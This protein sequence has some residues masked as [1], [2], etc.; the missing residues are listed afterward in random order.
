MGALENTLTQADID[1][2]MKSLLPANGEDLFQG[3]DNTTLRDYDFRRP[4]KFKK[5]LLRTLVMVHENYARLLQSFFLA[6]LRT[7]TQVH[8]RGTNQYLYAEYT[9]LLP[10][11]AVVA[12]FRLNP[13]PGICLLEISANIAY[14]VIDRVFGGPGSDTQ[15]QRG[16]SEIELSVIQRT[17][18]DVFVPLQEAWRNVAEIKPVLEAMETNPAFLQTS[19]P[20]EVLA[21]ITLGVQVGEHIGN[22]T[23]VFPYSTV[24]PVMS[25]LSPHRWL[26][27]DP[28]GEPDG[29]GLQ[30]SIQEA[31]VPLTAMLG[32]ARIT[33][34]EFTSLQEGDVIPLE[35]R[36]SDELSL[37]AGSVLTF[38]ARP[39]MSGNHMAVQITRRVPIAQG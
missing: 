20:S 3:K 21:A 2:L 4:T 29:E 32:T 1:A 15:P 33:V 24:A 11:P 19:S 7:N 23:L 37:Y 26:A 34:G 35:T 14:A 18:Q 25:K 12:V 6:S 28:T 39:G 9:Q 17:V 8:V 5:D 36:V 38:K 22:M 13:L 27:D 31:Q 16:L 30:G 10:S